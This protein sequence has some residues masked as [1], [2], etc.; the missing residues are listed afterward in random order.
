MARRVGDFGAA[1]ADALGETAE[2]RRRVAEL[3]LEASELRSLLERGGTER[4]QI[5]LL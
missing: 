5:C 4:D 3:D 2:T 1:L